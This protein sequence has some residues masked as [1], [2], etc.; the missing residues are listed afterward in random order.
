MSLNLD[1][2]LFARLSVHSSVR[3]RGPS[4]IGYRSRAID[5]IYIIASTKSWAKARGSGEQA[6][7]F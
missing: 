3:V 2:G 4:N 6:L 7:L 5:G 1:I